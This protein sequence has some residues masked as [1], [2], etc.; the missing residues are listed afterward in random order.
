MGTNSERRPRANLTFTPGINQEVSTAQSSTVLTVL[1]DQTTVRETD[2]VGI[3]KANAENKR[4]GRS[5]L[6]REVAA[7][8]QETEAFYRSPRLS[9]LRLIDRKSV[10]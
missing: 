1:P 3:P 2:S 5:Q 10:V 6:L 9:K 4:E 7:S 8:T